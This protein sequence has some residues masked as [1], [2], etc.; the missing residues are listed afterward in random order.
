MVETRLI[1]W[2]SPDEKPKQNNTF[3]CLV[4]YDLGREIKLL[5]YDRVFGWWFWEGDYHTYLTDIKYLRLL[6]WAEFQIPKF[7]NNL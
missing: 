5:N 3:L 2:K 6:A 4:K 1:R 7:V